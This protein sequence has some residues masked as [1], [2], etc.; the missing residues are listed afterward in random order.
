M[1]LFRPTVKESS[2]DEECDRPLSGAAPSIPRFGKDKRVSASPIRQLAAMSA[3][4]LSF[5]HAH[6]MLGGVSLS[7]TSLG[8]DS[9]A[10]E[11][12]YGK[13]VSGEEILSGGVKP[14]EAAHLMLSTLQQIFSGQVLERSYILCYEASQN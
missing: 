5:S 10:N 7:G 13:K 2:P 11:K 3:E 14:P 6:G 4:M 8:P 12:A 9:A 1:L